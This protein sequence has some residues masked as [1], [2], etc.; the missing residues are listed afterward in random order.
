MYE[1]IKKICKDK[2]IPVYKLEQDLGFSKGSIC[3]WGATSPSFERVKK[4][5]EYLKVDVNELIK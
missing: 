1:R 3:K 2:K 5:A 4:V